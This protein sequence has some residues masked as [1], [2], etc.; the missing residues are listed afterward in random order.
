M[1]TPF[2]IGIQESLHDPNELAAAWRLYS[3]QIQGK[4]TFTNWVG[5]ANEMNGL[6]VQYDED[7]FTERTGRFT[8]TRNLGHAVNIDSLAAYRR[9]FESIEWKYLT[10]NMN[11]LLTHLSEE[12]GVRRDLLA[13]IVMGRTSIRNSFRAQVTQD[14]MPYI[15]A[16]QVIDDVPNPSVAGT[17]QPHWIGKKGG[18]VAKRGSIAGG[19]RGARGSIRY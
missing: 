3:A 16:T 17:E 8:L 15:G 13:G 9:E 6:Y 18:S 10:I 1:Y 2:Q 19:K 12:F 7:R 11:S 5:K 4:N 14:I